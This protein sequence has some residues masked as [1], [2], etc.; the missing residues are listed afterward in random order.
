MTGG[1]LR[2]VEWRQGQEKGREKMRWEEGKEEA[3]EG[4]GSMSRVAGRMEIKRME[5][6]RKEELRWRVKTE[7]RVERVRGVP[8][9]GLGRPRNEEKE[10]KE[11]R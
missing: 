4:G 7:E 10:E 5:E 9:E 2:V 3:G 1:N 11:E 6:G 8:D